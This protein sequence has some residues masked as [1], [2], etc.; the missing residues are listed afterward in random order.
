MVKKRNKERLDKIASGEAKADNVSALRVVQGGDVIDIVKRLRQLMAHYES[1]TYAL[2]A[3][4]AEV[5]GASLEGDAQKARHTLEL[6]TARVAQLL[7][8]LERTEPYQTARKAAARRSSTQP[9]KENS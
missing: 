6:G 3:S 1:C 7:T 4:F 2:Y 5:G 8:H 9:P